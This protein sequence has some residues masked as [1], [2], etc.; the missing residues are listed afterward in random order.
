MG[1]MISQPPDT[2]RQCH[3]ISSLAHNKYKQ[4]LQKEGKNQCPPP[5]SI[6][7]WDLVIG[8]FLIVWLCHLHGAYDISV[9]EHI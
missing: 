7:V 9:P 4:Q 5:F 6:T 8:F 2:F 1:L 3:H